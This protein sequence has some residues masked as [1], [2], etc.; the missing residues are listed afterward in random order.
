MNDY[1]Q[2]GNGTT[3]NSEV[4]LNIGIDGWKEVSTGGAW[5]G[6]ESH[7]VAI[8]NDGSLWAWGSNRYGQLGDDGPTVGK[9][10]PNP[11]PIPIGTD[12]NWETIS[13]GSY[14]T[15]AIKTDGSLW[16]WGTNGFGQLGDST[17]T[18]R[19]SPNHIGTETN[20]KTVSAGSYHTAAIKTDGSLWAWGR[21]YSGQLGDG[22]GDETDGYNKS[23]P[24]LIDSG[25]WKAVFARYDTTVAI[26]NDGTLWAW[27]YNSSGQLGDG[28]TTNRNSPVEL[29]TEYKEFKWLS[30][31]VGGLHTVAIKTDGSLWAWGD[32]ISGQFGIPGKRYSVIPVQVGKDTN[33]KAVFAGYAHTVAI[34]NDGTLWAWGWNEYG[35]LGDG[36]TRNRTKPFRII[37]P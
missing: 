12:T 18:T 23:S 33:W 30:V 11:N 20:W 8:K 15:A 32:N 26:K 6:D 14:H 17:N 21:N 13:A 35:Q 3:K 37:E 22:N 27:G 36:G 31:S 10:D 25:P 9:T 19:N 16:A 29:A 4:S 7:T 2:L 5:P 1:G 28:T 34:K 24:V